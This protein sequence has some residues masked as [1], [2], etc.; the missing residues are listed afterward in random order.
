MSVLCGNPTQLRRSIDRPLHWNFTMPAAINVWF[1]LADFENISKVQF[2]YSL[3]GFLSIILHPDKTLVFLN[4]I[5]TLHKLR[6][7]TNQIMGSYSRCCC[8]ETP[9]K[10]AWNLDLFTCTLQEIWNI[11]SWENCQWV[12]DAF[13]TS[14]YCMKHASIIA[15]MQTYA[16]QTGLNI[17][18]GR[19]F[20]YRIF[21]K[22][23]LLISW[24]KWG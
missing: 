19:I 22:I 12:T 5:L 11:V 14:I 16:V 18:K 24:M 21:L 17:F 3:F 6:C 7:Y 4:K 23:S 8:K 1:L 9:S 20:D 10:T 15:S 2:L 13:I